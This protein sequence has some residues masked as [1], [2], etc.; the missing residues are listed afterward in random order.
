MIIEHLFH[1]WLLA[2]IISEL[3]SSLDST[4]NL[5]FEKLRGRNQVIG[6]DVFLTGLVGQGMWW[7]ATGSPTRS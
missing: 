6:Q 4:E 7:T 1:L 3:G 5:L 2:G